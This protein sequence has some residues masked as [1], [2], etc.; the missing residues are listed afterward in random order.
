MK[1]KF[2][3]R[4]LLAIWLLASIGILLM[5][6]LT[7]D[8]IWWNI[9]NI[10]LTGFDVLMAD[11]YVLLAPV[12][13]VGMALLFLRVRL[14]RR[15]REYRMRP[16]SLE[17]LNTESERLMKASKEIF[18]EGFL[19]KRFGVSRDELFS[20]PYDEH[21]KQIADFDRNQRNSKGSPPLHPMIIED[22]Q[23]HISRSMDN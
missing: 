2:S 13:I 1:T 20:G 3:N 18:Y 8:L 23:R 9:I 22:I 12:L 19:L 6:Y 7:R 16:F 5:F 11:A 14:K 21:L 4:S 10:N 15:D 17:E